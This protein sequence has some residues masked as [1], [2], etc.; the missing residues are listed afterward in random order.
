[1]EKVKGKAL[2]SNIFGKSTN[3]EVLDFL[4]MGKKLDFTLTQI[5]NGTGLSRTAIR[6]VLEQLTKDG[7]V[8]KSREDA[9][10]SYF[11]V[12]EE[13]SK[14]KILDNLYENIKK[15]VILSH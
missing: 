7:L 15:E 1:M 2:F 12:N 6:N 11:R 4:F 5:S 10:S 14:F 13:G 9:K 3:L 8:V